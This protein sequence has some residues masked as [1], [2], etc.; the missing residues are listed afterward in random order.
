VTQ[1]WPGV[2]GGRSGVPRRP[3]AFSTQTDGRKLDDMTLEMVRIGAVVE[4]RAAAW[5]SRS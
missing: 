5:Q 3:A 2:C 4:G 1:C